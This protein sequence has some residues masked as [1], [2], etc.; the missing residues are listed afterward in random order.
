MR[1]RNKQGIKRQMPLLSF[2]EMLKRDF[3]SWDDIDNF[4]EEWHIENYDCSLPE[5]LGMTEQQY[6]LW[7]ENPQLEGHILYL[8]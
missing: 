1:K 2:I 3:I 5:F 7:L 8:A 4:I 6:A